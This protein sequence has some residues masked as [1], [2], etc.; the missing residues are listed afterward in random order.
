MASVFPFEKNR[1]FPNKRLCAADFTRELAYIDRKFQLLQHW[2]LGEGVAF[3]LEV[4]RL[5]GETLL[6]SPGLALDSQGHYLAVEEPAICRLAA[7]PGF[8]DLTGE[9]ALLTLSYQEKKQTPLT[10]AD[11]QGT[12]KQEY[13]TALESVA[14]SLQKAGPAQNMVLEQLMVQTVLYQDSVLR[15]QQFLPRVISAHHPVSLRLVLDNLTLEPQKIYL[16]YAPRIPGFAL[17]P[18][19]L[20]EDFTLPLGRTTLELELRPK[21]PS[22]AAV[23]ELP[24][25]RFRLKIG[26]RL[27]QISP[28]SGEELTVTYEDPA[29][30]LEERCRSLTLEELQPREAEGIPIALVRFFRYQDNI[31][32]DDVVPV[33]G[34]PQA[35][36]PAVTRQLDIC[37]GFFPRQEKN[38]KPSAP[39]SKPQETMPVPG[40]MTT[41]LVSLHVGLDLEEDQVLHSKEIT[42]NL[43]LGTVYVDFGV[44]NVYPAARLERNCTDLILGDPSL[45]ALEGSSYI[46][47]IQRGIL[48]HPDRGTFELALRVTGELPQA[49]L[50]LRWFAWRPRE[51]KSLEPEGR[52]VGLDPD[53]LYTEPGTVVHF[54]PVFQGNPGPCEFFV[55]AKQAGLI[56][57]DGVYTVPDREG[58]YQ[59]CA[60]LRDN[61]QTKVSG[62]VIASRKERQSK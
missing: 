62:Y 5:D 35:I 36:F 28:P 39:P 46:P 31:L 18:E 32:L 52:L 25:E 49:V 1:Y 55:P 61:P 14:F 45:F 47:P 37:R 24:K 27:C 9:S 23:L 3:G 59:V 12:Q 51:E 15:V 50:Q 22:E 29:R 10:V 21:S 44:E 7:L 26:D 57:S 16:Y 42:H 13:G 17:E 33:P 20:D 48:V 40:Q 43:G 2:T 58:L 6:I 34:P 56:T 19:T 11:G 4:Q 41:G 8:D 53:V 54:A 38:P 30:A 60:R